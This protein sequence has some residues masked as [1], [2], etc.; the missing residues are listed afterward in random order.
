MNNIELTQ[1]Q[2]SLKASIEEFVLGHTSYSDAQ[3]EY[4]K[5][6][7]IIEAYRKNLDSHSHDYLNSL[8]AAHSSD[9][10]SKY[11][12]IILLK[13]DIPDIIASYGTKTVKSNITKIINELNYNIADNVRHTKSISLTNS[14]SYTFHYCKIVANENI[15][16][17]VCATSS[18]FFLYKTFKYF[19]ELVYRLITGSMQSESPLEFNYLANVKKK[20]FDFFN[21]NS[22]DKRKLLVKQYCFD[23]IPEMF[24][25]MGIDT[26]ADIYDRITIKLKR[27]YSINSLILQTSS[28]GFVVITHDPQP[29]EE[30]IF[31]FFEVTV[32]YTTKEIELDDKTDV[33]R[34]WL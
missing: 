24:S 23:D 17:I 21:K 11:T 15:Y 13:N 7:N 6:K 14:I 5:F 32:N 27:I 1:L 33:Y 25:H 22:F 28:I 26:L 30:L 31:S 2:A 9:N 34:L 3:K 20:I 18:Q 12:G 4:N 10:F 19:T 29:E 16:L 8:C